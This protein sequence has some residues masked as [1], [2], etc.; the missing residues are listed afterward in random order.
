MGR[1][2]MWRKRDLFRWCFIVVQGGDDGGL[3]PGGISRNIG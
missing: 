2:K 1:M 3:D